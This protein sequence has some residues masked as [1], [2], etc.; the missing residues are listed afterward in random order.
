MNKINF[1]KTGGFPL[2]TERLQ[3]IFTTLSIF[4]AFGQLAG[5]LT[6]VSG[7]D[8]IGTTVKNGFVFIDGELLEFREASAVNE[9]STVI[10][11]EENKEAT[12]ENGAVKTVHIVR[13]ATIGSA[14]ISWPWNSFKRPFPTKDIEEFRSDFASRLNLIETKLNGIEE[15]AQ[16]NVQSDFNVN[17]TA[18]NAYIKNKPAFLKVLYQNTKVIGNITSNSYSTVISFPNIGTSNYQVLG[19]FRSNSA[20]FNLDNNV[21]HNTREHSATSFRLCIREMTND[22]QNVSF[23]YTIVEKTS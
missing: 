18:S 15:N 14:E 19:S 5:N 7:C 16:K 9:S 20:N 1:N 11:I 13:Y 8:K 10:I 21:F 12:F 4:N 2:K 22:D 6:I 17:D 3:E 23:D